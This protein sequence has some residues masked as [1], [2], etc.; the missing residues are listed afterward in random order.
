MRDDSG[1]AQEV[2]QRVV[3]RRAGS[4]T[5]TPAAHRPTAS[6]TERGSRLLVLLHCQEPL[7]A[8]A[9]TVAAVLDRRIDALLEDVGAD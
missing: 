4:S 9:A 2:R 8:S 6:L 1:L 3:G 7:P 5:G